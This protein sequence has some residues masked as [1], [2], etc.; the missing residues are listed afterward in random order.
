MTTPVLQGSGRRRLHCHLRGDRRATLN[1]DTHV[2][3]EPADL[4]TTRSTRRILAVAQFTADDSTEC[5]TGVA[6]AAAQN[7]CLRRGREL[8]APAG[9][10]AWT[11]RELC[12]T[13]IVV[14]YMSRS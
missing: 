5:L 2:D 10:S 11:S 12:A 14:L 8:N 4:A 1:G 3:T 13:S 9:Q 7:P 6:V